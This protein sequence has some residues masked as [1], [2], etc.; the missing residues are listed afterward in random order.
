MAIG[1]FDR[2]RNP[3][4][5]VASPFPGNVGVLL[6]DGHGGFAPEVDISPIL[7]AVSIGV[8]DLDGDGNPDLVI[9]TGFGH[10]GLVLL[11]DGHGGF[12]FPIKVPTDNGPLSVAVGDLD[13]DADPD[14]A[15]AAIVDDSVSVLLNART[16][17]RADKQRIRAALADRLPTGSRVDD[18]AITE[19][20]KHLDASLVSVLWPDANH[21]DP[22][23]G[24]TVFVA[25]RAAVAQLEKVRT[26][27]AVTRLKGLLVEIDR[28][29]AERAI[30]E[31]PPV[32]LNP[33][34]QAK[35]NSELAKARAELARGDADVEAGRRTRAID[36]Y[37]EAWEHAQ[38]A[39][40]TSGKSPT[41]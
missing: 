24:A 15:F 27:D 9:G 22:G 12:A 13:G 11:G 25:E 36:H 8:A 2:D 4:L 26:D 32:A 19:A 33:A 3:D 38:K 14:L 29:L 6:G 35:V 23:Q 31:T 16:S 7:L 20:L 18:L 10:V 39:T 40:T 34:R 28:D 5:A 37:R 17:A 30:N 1:D 41:V 21:V